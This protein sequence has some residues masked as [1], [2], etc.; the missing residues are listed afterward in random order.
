MKLNTLLASTAIAAAGGHA[1][2]AAPAATAPKAP[3]VE[4]VIAG[5]G[6]VKIEMPERRSNRGS[7][8]LYPFDSLAVGTAFGV[9]NKKAADMS[10][11]I[12]NQNRK[13]LVPKKD[14]AG[15]AM[16]E[17][18]TLAGSDGSVTNVPD[19]T[20]PITEPSK[21]FYAVDVNPDL[22]AKI[23]GTELE[24]SSV[25]VFREI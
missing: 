11:I 9:K 12:S 19:T 7:V 14:E 21:R 25:L 15:N 6:G 24:G 17:T 18:K 23:K 4:P 8:S 10:S 13:H 1:N 5:A 22:K 16:F 2:A 3:R 20:K